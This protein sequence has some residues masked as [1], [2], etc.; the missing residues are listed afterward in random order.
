MR[1]GAQAPR[2]SCALRLPSYSY[3]R[4]GAHIPPRDEKVTLG[5]AIFTL[6]ER[7]A[8]L[9]SCDAPSNT[10]TVR[11]E[12][13]FDVRRIYVMPPTKTPI[14]F[15]DIQAYLDAIADNPNNTGDVESSNHRRF[16][17]TT[18]LEFTTGSVPLETCNN[19]PIP[20]VGKVAGNPNVDPAQC[21]FFQAL[22]SPTGWCNKG[23]MP[24]FGPPTSFITDQNY[25][26]TLKDGTVL[27]GT[28]IQD[29]ITWWLGHGLPEK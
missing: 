8:R 27:T 22:T 3:L 14:L 20:I 1:Y 12:S 17:Q 28:Q 2:I 5:V 26:I 23:T 16:W 4:R 9:D 15:A 18:Y 7:A 29:N 19:A 11:E 10:L 6:L 24:K 21:P 25:K 13:A